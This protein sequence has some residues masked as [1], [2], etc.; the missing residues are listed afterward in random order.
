M[1]IVFAH[2]DDIV[3]PVLVKW[4]GIVDVI[5][6]DSACG[7]S[8]RTR[9]NLCRVFTSPQVVFRNA[10]GMFNRSDHLGYL[11]WLLRRTVKV[12]EVV[13]SPE[14]DTDS[15]LLVQKYI[16][17]CG[18]TVRY[19]EFV[20]YDSKVMAAAMKYC[21]S[22]KR[23]SMYGGGDIEKDT[24]LYSE[25]VETFYLCNDDDNMNDNI[26][27]NFPNLTDL[28]LVGSY[29][30]DQVLISAVQHSPNLKKIKL[31]EAQ[32]LTA[33]SYAA[34]GQYCHLLECVTTYDVSFSSAHLKLLLPFTPK[35]QEL[36]L[37][38]TDGELDAHV[39]FE[40]VACN[41]PNLTELS[42][43]NS[44][45]GSAQ[46]EVTLRAFVRVLTNCTH[47]QTLTLE[48]CPFV[49]DDYLLAIAATAT[50][51]RNL[52]L[53][54]CH[55]SDAGLA[56][57]AKQCIALEWVSVSSGV[58]YGAGIDCW[59]LFGKE[60]KVRI[61]DLNKLHGDAVTV[62]FSGGGINDVVTH[63]DIV[64]EYDETTFD[65]DAMDVSDG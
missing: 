47:L 8:R 30:N 35:L 33:A 43:D 65:P 34:I 24:I 41:C 60:T 5:R 21:M 13:I 62:R 52:H 39:V 51:L 54:D 26:C 11:K 3:I 12:M 14:M 16:T 29:V 20:F 10:E 36:T 15:K 57:V 27:I 42:F 59:K 4:L 56:E 31:E 63:I 19:L 49:T 6:L 53:P 25:S 50:Q 23:L 9:E 61:V 32:T 28:T 22:L 46:H 58:D 45:G 48:R 1:D 44:D 64:S 2:S 55:I 17:L 38:H 7:F 18:S 40:T 37:C